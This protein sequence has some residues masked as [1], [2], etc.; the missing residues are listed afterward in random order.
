[1]TQLIGKMIT[2][3]E[4][5]A[6]AQCLEKYLEFDNEDLKGCEAVFEMQTTNCKTNNLFIDLMLVSKNAVVV[7][8]VKAWSKLHNDLPTY[9]EKANKIAFN[10]KVAKMTLSINKIY[11]EGWK[12]IVIDEL[13]EYFLEN[14]TIYSEGGGSECATNAHDLATIL[15]YSG[16]STTNEVQVDD[17]TKEKAHS[18]IK[19]ISSIVKKQ[20]NRDTRCLHEK[21]WKV[22]QVMNIEIDE[23]NVNVGI[24]INF[25]TGEVVLD[26]SGC[27]GIQYEIAGA[28]LRQGFKGEIRDRYTVFVKIPKPLVS[29]KTDIYYADFLINFIFEVENTK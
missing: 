21:P 13:A 6:L 1:M 22:M 25:I 3:S 24:G 19:N 28:I 29:D 23:Y 4:H 18:E 11:E 17:N 9:Y 12:S 7:I 2:S 26:I 14:A 27:L 5:T 15:A 16:Y 20:L 10:R 8:E